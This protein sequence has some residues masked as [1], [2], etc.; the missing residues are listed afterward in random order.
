MRLATL[1]SGRRGEFSWEG[2]TG[3]VVVFVVVA[4]PGAIVAAFLTSR[5]RWALSILLSVLLCLPATGIASSDLGSLDGLPTLRWVGVI[6]AAGGVY[7]SIL[8]LPWV[9]ARLMGARLGRRRDISGAP[10]S[11]PREQLSS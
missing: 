8:A 4:L 5:F 3:I 6:A 1:A 11:H 9:T 2:T 7:V 10:A